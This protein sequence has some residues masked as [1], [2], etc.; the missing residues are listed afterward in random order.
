MVI[1]C[2]LMRRNEKFKILVGSTHEFSYDSEGTEG[3][4]LGRGVFTFYSSFF[5][6]QVFSF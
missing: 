6:I 2:L 3:L 4:H 1:I 5:S